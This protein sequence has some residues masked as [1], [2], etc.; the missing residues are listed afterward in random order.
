MKIFFNKTFDEMMS[1]EGEVYR[2]QDNRKTMRFEH[3]G[4][5]YFIKQHFGVGWKE[6]FKNLFQFRL[7]VISARNE[8]RAIQKLEMLNI[9][10][11]KVAAFCQRY[12]NPA[13]RQSFVVTHELQNVESLEDVC[14]NWEKKPPMFAEK[15]K[16]I[17][18]V[19][20][21]ARTIHANGVNHRDF[22]LC[23]FLRG[24]D[25]AL[26]LIDLHRVQIR[27]KT[28]MRWIIKDVSGLYFSAMDIGLTRNDILR[29]LAYYFNRPWRE[30]IASKQAFL[31]RV[32]E[33]AIA[34][35]IKDHHR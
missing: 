2:D 32:E 16:I 31:K 24:I 27:A 17:R 29:F 20:F 1:I 14:R 8:W 3:E 30:V 6:I 9:P 28:P 26:Y 19:A 23:H 35:Y 11:M 7:P 25:Q 10:T 12:F 4:K 13:R 15:L 5:I 33:R 18:D 34:L 21:V 22:Y